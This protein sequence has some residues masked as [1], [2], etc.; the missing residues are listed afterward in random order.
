[1]KK[2]NLIELPLTSLLLIFILCGCSSSQKPASTDNDSASFHELYDKEQCSEYHKNGFSRISIGE[3]RNVID[4]DTVNYDEVRFECVHISFITQK[5]L[6]D[7]FG[8]WDK[9]LTQQD[10]HGLLLMWQ[11]VDLFSNGKRYTVVADGRES[12][13]ITYGSFMAFNQEGEDIVAE[14]LAEKDEIIK[15]FKKWIR[16]NDLD[17]RAFFDTYWPM[18]REY[19]EKIK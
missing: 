18:Y 4:N 17:D 6:F 13:N 19:K 12:R 5:V 10:Y 2:L 9:A 15:L 1:M 11:N 16:N 8:K 3:Y 7:H 14:N